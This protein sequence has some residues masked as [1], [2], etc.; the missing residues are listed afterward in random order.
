MSGFTEKGYVECDEGEHVGDE[1]EESDQKNNIRINL[2]DKD[3]SCV[4]DGD[5]TCAE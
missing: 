4:E 1:S 2:I 3:G 5:D